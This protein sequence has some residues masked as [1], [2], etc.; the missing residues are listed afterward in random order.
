MRRNELES[1][2]H[3]LFTEL[4]DAVE[5]G[6]LGILT[7]D[8]SPR[9]IPLNFAAIGETVYF[10][11]ALAGEKFEMTKADARCSFSIVNPFSLIPSYWTSARHACPATHFFKSIEIR[12]QYELVDDL[13][14]KAQALQAI[15]EKYQP[16]GG[17]DPI[18]VGHPVYDKAL[19]GVGVYRITGDWTGKVKFGRNESVQHRH[20]WIE[21]LQA[22]G[23]SRDLETAREIQR[24]IESG[25][26]AD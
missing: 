13:D 23:T 8:G 19:R 21:K 10:H 2:D 5:V 12:G 25:G 11:G 4:A 1:H 24:S 14:E 9:V 16:E 18:S 3:E 15:M 20:L 6:Q 22:R 26:D 17:H 7:A